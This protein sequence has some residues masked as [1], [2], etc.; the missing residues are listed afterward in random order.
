[1][2]LTIRYAEAV[3]SGRVEN[4]VFNGLLEAMCTDLSKA[5]RGV[6][7]QNFNYAPAWDE[8]CHI[9]YIVSLRAYRIL[10]TYFPARTPRSFR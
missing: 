10:R 9:I 2:A 6:G 4:N 3:L 7:L 5:E 8:L 1:M